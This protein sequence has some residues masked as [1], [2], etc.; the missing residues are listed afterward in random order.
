MNSG[1]NEI[2]L[3]LSKT[4]DTITE[5]RDKIFRIAEQSRMELYNKRY[6]LENT[7]ELIK[8]INK[9]IKELEESEIATKNLCEAISK[10]SGDFNEDE[11]KEIF[12]NVDK[13]EKVVNQNR[14]LEKNFIIKRTSLEFQIKNLVSI[15]KKSGEFTDRMAISL[16]TLTNSKLQKNNVFKNR[17]M[18]IIR[19]QEEERKRISR[20]MHD[21][22]AQHMA[23]MVMNVDYCEK[24]LES[25]PDRLKSELQQLKVQL[26]EGAKNIRRIIFDLMPVSLEDLGLIPTLE[27]YIE[28]LNS[29]FAINIEFSYKKN[30]MIDIP[31]IIRL[32][33]FRIIQE[34]L[35]NAIKHADADNVFVEVIV[36]KESIELSVLDD[37]KGLSDDNYM[38]DYG[39]DSGFGMYGIKERVRLL[40]GSIKIES[41]KQGINGFKLSAVLPL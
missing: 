38:P 9:E 34:A 29:R 26:K 40:N 8:E 33:V 37:G 3:I 25:N 27:N 11:I 24:L 30:D 10:E 4:V 36:S 5:A 32:S 1:L 7:N 6:E 19:A 13:I 23:G 35:N 18:E 41:I 2:N 31:D 20:E 12:G 14:V 15:L 16:D 22:P 39:E 28:G 17:G 21:G